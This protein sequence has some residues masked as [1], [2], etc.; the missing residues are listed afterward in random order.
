[1]VKEIHLQHELTQLLPD[2]KRHSKSG[3]EERF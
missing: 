3:T 2:E 1:M